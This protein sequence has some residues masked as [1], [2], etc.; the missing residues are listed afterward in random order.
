MRRTSSTGTTINVLFITAD[1]TEADYLVYEIRARAPNIHLEVFPGVQRAIDHFKAGCHDAVLVDHRLS[2]ADRSEL[3]AYIQHLGLATPIILI[4]GPDIDNPT[5][6]MLRAGADAHVVRGPNFVNELPV[7]I[8][9]ALAGSQSEAKAS[10]LKSSPLKGDSLKP[11]GPGP[12]STARTPAS[13]PAGATA[14]PTGRQ[15]SVSDR[16]ISQRR[17]VRIP[18]RLEWHGNSGA[19]WL[20]DLSEEGA[21][22]ETSALMAAGSEIVIQFDAAGTEVRLEATVTH[23]GWYL[24]TDRNFD[25]FGVQLR[26]L[27]PDSRRILQELHSKSTKRAQPKT[28]LER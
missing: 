4:F 11:E 26:N 16:R 15:R 8:Q 5:I 17:E 14:A 3:I 21:F 1:L 24:S 23:H 2:D 12:E 20:H 22:L 6:R 7:I 25:G 13:P 28:T 9:Q 27:T 18:C 10:A 19:A